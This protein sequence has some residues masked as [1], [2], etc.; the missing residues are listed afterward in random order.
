MNL[1]P[2]ASRASLLRTCLVLRALWPWRHS[3]PRT[4]ERVRLCLRRLREVRA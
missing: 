1:P 3:C 4:R 2:L